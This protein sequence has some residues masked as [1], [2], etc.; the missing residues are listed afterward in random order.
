ME[1]E[2]NRWKQCSSFKVAWRHRRPALSFCS[3]CWR[4]PCNLYAFSWI[5]FSCSRSGVVP[6]LPSAKLRPVP[7]TSEAGL[8][9]PTKT[10][11]SCCIFSTSLELV[12][13]WF[14][15]MHE[16]WG[17][18]LRALRPVQEGTGGGS[19]R[20]WDEKT[21]GPGRGTRSCASWNQILP[22]RSGSGTHSERSCDH[23][24]QWPL[25]DQ[26]HRRLQCSCS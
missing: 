23:S 12:V 16:N 26:L 4:V 18:P 6:L 17:E 22:Q 9:T 13:V 7:G 14:A 21:M 3:N 15:V 11:T 24:G 1:W 25:G 2:H 20:A 19:A 5:F 10:E 8:S